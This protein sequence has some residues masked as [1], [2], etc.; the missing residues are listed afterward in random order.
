LLDSLQDRYDLYLYTNN[1][2]PLA[3]KILALLGIEELFRRLYTIEFTWSPKPDPESFHQVLEDI[4]GPPESFLF[5]GDRPQ[6][7]LKIAE[8]LQI[9]TIFISDPEDLLQIHKVL[10]L[11]P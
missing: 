7:D 8:S 4:G 5:V 10:G 2:L 1:S 9:P 11:I 3:Q 6:V